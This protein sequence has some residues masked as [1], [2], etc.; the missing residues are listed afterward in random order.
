MNANVRTVA[1]GLGWFSLALGI[2]ELTA[3][4][5]VGRASGVGERTGLLR[6]YGLRELAAGVGILMAGG[7]ERLAPWLWSRVAG[8]A[9]DLATLVPALRTRRGRARA[10]AAVAAVAG[11]TAVDAYCAR[12]L[13]SA[14]GRGG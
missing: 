8:D 14:P 12:R 11:V 2:A 9:V 6:M 1:M 7:A 5:A 10:A 13:S 3:P 4:R